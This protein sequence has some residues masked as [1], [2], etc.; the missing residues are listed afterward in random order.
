[1]S[2]QSHSAQDD[3]F[4]TMIYDHRPERPIR[5]RYASLRA[6]S[7][8][9]TTADRSFENRSERQRI[10]KGSAFGAALLSLHMKSATEEWYSSN[11]YNLGTV[12]LLLLELFGF[13]VEELLELLLLFV[14]VLLFGC[15]L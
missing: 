3:S 13:V 6:G 8:P 12:V 14:P 10:K 4:V 11:C 1:M 7:A 2:C 15:F 9:P 5:L